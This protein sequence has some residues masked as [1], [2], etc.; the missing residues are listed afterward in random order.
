[1]AIQL[2]P[3]SG[4]MSCQPPPVVTLG[5]WSLSAPLA[6]GDMDLEICTWRYLPHLPNTMHLLGLSYHNLFTYTAPSEKPPFHP[7][8]PQP[9]PWR[10]LPSFLGLL[11][12]NCLSPPDC[13]DLHPLVWAHHPFWRVC[14]LFQSTWEWV[15]WPLW[16]S[17]QP[18][19]HSRT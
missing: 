14:T 10:Y 7:T 8:F 2:G 9:T 15:W 12:W 19:N 6:P 11:F 16:G 13:Q 5:G 17:P 4:L 1:M 3:P 18:L